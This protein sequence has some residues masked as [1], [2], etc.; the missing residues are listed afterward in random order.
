M[1]A[2]AGFFA[3]GLATGNGPL[4]DFSAHVADPFNVNIATNGVSVP[5]Y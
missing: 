3:Q 4:A 5:I 1:F 2:M